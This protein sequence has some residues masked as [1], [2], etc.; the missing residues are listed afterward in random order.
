M[1]IFSSIRGFIRR[2]RWKLIIAAA[3][4]LP[5]GAFVLYA[6]G[7]A[8]AEY[9][10]TTA[11][12]GDLRQTVEAVGTV[13]SE[14]DLELKFGVSGIVASVSVKTGDRVRAG[15]RLAT[16]RSGSESA[17]IAA[18]AARLASAQ[19]DLRQLEQGARA[20][21][22]AVSQADLDSARAS[23]EVAR[24]QRD[25]AQK[26]LE[27]SERKL[28]SIKS[29]I[30]VAAQGQL[31]EIPLTVQAQLSK[32]RSALVTID[33]VFAN[34][35]VQDAILKSN[36]SDYNSMR[37]SVTDAKAKLDAVGVPW[38]DKDDIDTAYALEAESMQALLA[39]QQSLEWAY[40]I[41]LSLDESSYLTASAREGYG[42]QIAAQRTTIDA[43]VL[44]L[45]GA[46]SSLRDLV[47]SQQTQLTTEESAIISAQ[48]TFDRASADILTYEATIRSR[49][50]QLNLKRTGARQTEL[51]SARA[52]VREASA[53]LAS[54]QAAMADNVIVAP[55]SGVITKVDVKPGEITP[56]GAAVTMLG[57]SPF[58][59]EMF[60]SEI[61]IPKVA[62][63]QDATVELD[64][65]PNVYMKLKVR[66][67]DTAPTEVDG[68]LK[69]R[70]K[71]D[72]VY[73]HDELKIGMSG[74][75]TIVTG[76]RMGV[77]LAPRRSV[78]R[79]DDDRTYVRL[80]TQSGG[81]MNRY[82]EMG[83]EGADGN[84]EIRRG[85]AGDET[86]IQLT[87]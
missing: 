47:A 34:N 58:R 49:E 52:R 63:D 6:R 86:I 71:L 23:L 9:I 72:F 2:N 87:K 3:I 73:P 55:S 18:A 16:L 44:T 84:V 35:D 83:M 61:D 1:P 74:D 24:I 15:Q 8:Q 82:V 29:E 50:A 21:D 78:L 25:T 17:Q 69:Y 33:D 20:E 51:D 12:R 59:I 37:K 38:V 76:E 45:R 28:E 26:S 75:V 68:V 11:S 85:L 13:V 22:I 48:N 54:A 56:A 39:T 14:R 27:Q 10:T 62:L 60:V 57:D 53:N 46:F 77:I 30:A 36:P 42:Q 80:L 66:E 81:V 70:V 41:V 40:N 31:T 67:I 79:D 5:L 43:S 7:P 19:A 32:A 65:F 4:L 64:A